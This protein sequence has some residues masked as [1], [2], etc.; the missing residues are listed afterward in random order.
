MLRKRIIAGL[1]VIGLMSAF[2]ITSLA[3]SQSGNVGEVIYYRMELRKP[4]LWDGV[5]GQSNATFAVDYSWIQAGINGNAYIYMN[6]HDWA[7]TGSKIAYVKKGTNYAE[8]GDLE[9]SGYR[10]NVRSVHDCALYRQSGGL[11]MELP[12]DIILN[13]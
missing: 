6:S 12:S 11:Y 9:A 2:S 13:V 8:P 3:A 4:L 5:K 7:Y 10:K 1:M